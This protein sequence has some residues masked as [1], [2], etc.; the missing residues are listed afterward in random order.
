MADLDLAVRAKDAE[1]ARAI[2][3]ALDWKPS[4]K[5]PEREIPDLHAQDLRHP[6][7]AE[8]DLHWHCLREAPSEAL[9][10][11]FWASAKPFAFE[12]LTTLRPAPTQMLLQTI[13]HGVRSNDEPPIRWIS[14]A[15][16]VIG[17]NGDEINW[18]EL[19]E[20]AIKYRMAHR[21]ALGLDYLKTE[22]DLPIP[23]G[24][25]ARLKARPISIIE[26]VENVVYLGPS[27]RLYQPTLYPLVDYWRFKRV[28]T[29]RAFVWGFPGYLCRRWN[30]SSPWQI[31]AHAFAAL[32]RRKS[33]VA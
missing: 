18:S 16:A 7:G 26:R 22:Y 21:L 17:D 15:A 5:H 12:Q 4:S 28:Q 8:I 1:K 20:V 9:D 13:L 32:R 31:P 30:L 10:D 25:I 27:T 29:L 14:D 23:G 24:V 2:L 33:A 11:W 19:T 3:A 6:S